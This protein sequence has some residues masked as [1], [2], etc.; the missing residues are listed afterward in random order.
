VLAGATWS[1][2]GVMLLALAA[3][4]LTPLRVLPAVA[5]AAIGIGLGVTAWRALFQRL[6]TANIDRLATRP[7]RACVFGFVA[8]KG[9]LTMVAMIALGVTLRHSSLPHAWLAVGY[10][11]I[12]AALLLASFSYYTYLAHPN[13]RPA[14]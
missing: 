10:S 4:W 3:R 1:A 6:A 8:P 2:V 13:E 5:L 7:A 14:S 11:A 12:G 9:W